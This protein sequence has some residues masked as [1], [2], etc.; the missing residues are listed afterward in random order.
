MEK[1][2]TSLEERYSS[3]SNNNSSNRNCGSNDERRSDRQISGSSSPAKSANGYVLFVSN[4]NRKA[5]DSSVSDALVDAF[6]TFG[7]VTNIVVTLDRRTGF[8]KGYALVEFQTL[9]EAKKC[10]DEMNGQNLSYIISPEGGYDVS[11]K[12][13]RISQPISIDWAFSSS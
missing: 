9:Q 11:S 12:S 6:S 7:E 3:N 2:R 8:I 4:L 10:L 5:S 1:T 13:A